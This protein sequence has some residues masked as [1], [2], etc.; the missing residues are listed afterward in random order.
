MR[1]LDRFED[2]LA[3]PTTEVRVAL[4]ILNGAFH[5]FILVVDAKRHLL[6]TV[7]DGDVRRAMLRGATL[8]G[9]I[10]QCMYREPIVGRAG[11][12]KN[13][14]ALLRGMPFLP[15]V[16]DENRVLD[17]L[18]PTNAPG[19]VG[20]A[21]VMA[22]GLGKRLGPITE[23]TPKPL[24]LVGGKPIIEH[25]LG[26][27][28]AAGVV[29]IWITVNH[30]AEQV[31]DFVEARQ[32][33]AQIELLYEPSQLGT[34]GSLSLLPERPTNPILVLNGDVLTHV[35]YRALESFHRRSSFDGTIAVAHHRI[36]VPF[37][38]V[39]HDGSGIFTEID[40]KPVLSHFVAGGIYYLS[41]ELIAL[42]P[43]GRQID[44]PDILN[45]AHDVGMRIGLFPIHEYWADVGRPEDL[46]AAEIFHTSG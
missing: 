9:S 40:E 13:H 26:N 2:Y 30:L 41:P 1:K 24:L 29:R 39:R 43:R 25:I 46:T 22:G 37:G 27:L 44:M 31:R 45:E 8:D 32:S 23:H 28:E 5:Q 42:V 19:G 18:L 21:V 35:D 33:V 16:D 36:Q 4:Q 17:I 7:T 14:A 6:G 11:D 34:A 10:A 20:E 15:L 12:T 38:V 3:L